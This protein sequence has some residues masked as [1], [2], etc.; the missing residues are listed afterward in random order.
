MLRRSNVHRIMCTSS[1][2]GRRGAFQPYAYRLTTVQ[3]SSQFGYLFTINSTS[4]YNSWCIRSKFLILKPCIGC[5]YERLLPIGHERSETE[6]YVIDCQSS[7][8][9]VWVSLHDQFIILIRFLVHPNGFSHIKT[10][11]WMSVRTSRADQ[12]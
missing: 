6:P 10:V 2:L 5:L 11:H 12:T 7:S 9:A 8:S 4:E 1:I 3:D